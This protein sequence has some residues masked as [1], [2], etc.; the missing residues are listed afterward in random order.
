MVLVLGILLGA[1]EREITDKDVDKH[2]VSV[3][4]VRRLIDLGQKK[5]RDDVILLV[6][7]RSEQDFVKGHLPGARNIQI[8]D[9]KPKAPIDKSIDR[10]KN[11]IVYGYDPASASARG[12]TKRLMGKGYDNVAFYSGGVYQ[13]AATG[14]ELVT[15]EPKQAQ[16]ASPPVP[17]AT[18]AASGGQ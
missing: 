18:A 11:I 6:D 13:W 10:Y 16:G 17:A 1:C 5:N 7:S 12:M 15:S 9:I 2:T 8:S 4:E 3:S 14:G